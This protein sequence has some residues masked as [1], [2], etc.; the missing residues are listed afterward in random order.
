MNDGRAVYLSRP[1]NGK[2]AGVDVQ[3]VHRWPRHEQ[4]KNC[5]PSDPLH[6]QSGVSHTSPEQFST[7]GI[8][9]ENFDADRVTN[10]INAI[11]TVESVRM[12]V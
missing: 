11:D 10:N 5:R 6:F 9:C 4:E 2:V 1:P 7:F 8:S 3:L 12:L